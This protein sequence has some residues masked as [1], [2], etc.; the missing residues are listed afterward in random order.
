MKRDQH[1]LFSRMQSLNIGSAK[2][3]RPSD[4]EESSQIVSLASDSE[5]GVNQLGLV[6]VSSRT[7]QRLIFETTCGPL[8]SALHIALCFP[9]SQLQ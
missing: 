3:A 7:A 8:I 6:M 5:P 2:P 4:I 9:P 1:L